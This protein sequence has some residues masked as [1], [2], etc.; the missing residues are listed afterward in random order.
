[1]RRIAQKGRHR[2][3]NDSRYNLQNVTDGFAHRSASST[4]EDAL[5]NRICTAYNEAI[6]RHKSAPP[7]YDASKWW[8]EVRTRGLAPVTDALSTSDINGL[9]KMYRNFFRDPC[10]TGLVSVPYGM[11]RA[12]F[13]GQIKDVHRHF[14]LGDFLHRVDYWTKESGGQYTL[15]DLAA[16]SIG[17]PFGVT[18]A[19]TF[20]RDGAAYQHYCAHKIAK[21]L[22]VQMSVVVEIGG[23]FGGMAYYLLRDHPGVSYLGLDVPESLA[24]ASYYLMTAFPQLR[25]LLYGEGEVTEETIAQFDVILLPLCELPA[26]P[27]NCVDLS[28]SSHALSDITHEASGDYLDNVARTTRRFFYCIGV[29]HSEQETTPPTCGRYGSF[30]LVEVRTLEWNSH[31]SAASVEVECVYQVKKDTEPLGPGTAKPPSSERSDEL[32]KE[33]FDL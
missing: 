9:Q 33:S 14:Y 10:S 15:R 1:M 21:L 27:D 28:F 3:E 24:L 16:P 23:G 22:G 30:K 12:Y 31:K 18:I 4:S 25:F 8:A 20:I 29:A 13:D 7:I 32:A 17:N 2:Y 5:L 11:S 26:I 6:T 19:G